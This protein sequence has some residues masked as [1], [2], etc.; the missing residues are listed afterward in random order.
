LKTPEQIENLEEAIKALCKRYRTINKILV[1]TKF[2]QKDD[3]KKRLRK[4]VLERFPSVEIN[5]CKG[6]SPNGVPESVP[7]EALYLRTYSFGYC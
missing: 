2:G 7:I 4:F 5:V 6:Q 1:L 3:L